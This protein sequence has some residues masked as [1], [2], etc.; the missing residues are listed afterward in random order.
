MCSFNLLIK[1]FRSIERRCQVA[2]SP[3]SY[4]VRTEYTYLPQ[5]ASPRFS[6][7]L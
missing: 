7:S 1:M 2:N 5:T 3:D 6:Q 4:L